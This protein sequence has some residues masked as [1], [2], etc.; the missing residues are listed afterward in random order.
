MDHRNAVI[1]SVTI[2][3]K[4]I[5][6]RIAVDV[7]LHEIVMIALVVVVIILSLISTNCEVIF[8]IQLEMGAMDLVVVAE[9][10]DRVTITILGVNIVPI[11]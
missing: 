7:S 6:I 9:H 1:V 11:A 2:T 3:R 4:K 10:L 8:S 5:I